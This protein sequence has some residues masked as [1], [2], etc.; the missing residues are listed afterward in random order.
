MLDSDERHGIL[1]GIVALIVAYQLWVTV[2]L[3]RAEEYET[4]QKRLH[5][6]D[7]ARSFRRRD[8][9]HHA[10]GNRT[11]PPMTG[12]LYAATLGEG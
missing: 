8:R 12:A 11:P 1:L 7:L 3:F 9:S 10:V 2:L 4:H 5:W 6:R